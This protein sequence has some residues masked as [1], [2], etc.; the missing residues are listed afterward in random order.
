LEF[1]RKTEQAELEAKGQYTQ[2]LQSREQQFRDATAERDKRIAELEARTRELEILSPAKSAL[3][4][5]VHDPDV[6]L[7]TKLKVDQIE[8]EADGS[9]VV[10]NGYERTPV[11]EWARRLPEWMQKAPRPQGSGAPTSRSAASQLPP[12]TKNPFTKEGFNL[13]EQHRLF[14]TDPEFAKR[15]QDAARR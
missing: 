15:L 14:N 3:A 6:V 1:K 9:V 11:K 8:R 7:Q 2:A 5:I 10:V 12:G 13:T 4:E